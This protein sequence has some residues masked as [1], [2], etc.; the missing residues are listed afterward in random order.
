MH[1]RH[2][3]TLDTPGARLK[4]HPRQHPTILL[5]YRP[6]TGRTHQIRVHLQYAG[7]PIANDWQYGGRLGASRSSAVDSVQP[8]ADAG[9]AADGQP[10]E[11]PPASTSPLNQ[12]AAPAGDTAVGTP[13][14]QDEVSA[15]CSG[16][17][18]RKGWV[19]ASAA[20]T[21]PPAVCAEVRPPRQ[22]AIS[23][24]DELKR[25]A[26]EFL[27]DPGDRDA[28][29]T[30]CPSL[31]PRG[32]QHVP[33]QW[34]RHSRCDLHT[35]YSHATMIAAPSVGIISISQSRY[36]LCF[37]RVANG[38]ECAVAAR[39]QLLVRRVVLQ[40]PAAAVGLGAFAV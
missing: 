25:A 28:L 30:H 17:G 20:S 26:A 2:S 40:K 12:P 36:S 24:A 37:C 32:E 1:P 9:P 14:Q 38:A 8:A 27:V 18:S 10:P 4:G 35:R 16:N 21:Q 11:V 6:K 7:H 5:S 3:L 13:G 34:P 31:I 39:S 29:C 33:V 19:S 22:F 23:E 15:Q